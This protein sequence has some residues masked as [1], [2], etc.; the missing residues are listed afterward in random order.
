MRPVWFAAFSQMLPRLQ[1]EEALEER[2]VVASGTGSMEERDGRQYVRN[3]Q[4][5]ASGGRIPGA[6][7][8][9]AAALAQIGIPVQTLDADGKE[10]KT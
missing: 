8:A 6:V 2:L 7:K 3:L 4:R 9:S 5:A 1:A 10:V